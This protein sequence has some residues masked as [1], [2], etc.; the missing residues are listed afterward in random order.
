MTSSKFLSDQELLNQFQPFVDWDLK[1]QDVN[2]IS[3][4]EFIPMLEVPQV[5]RSMGIPADGFTFVLKEKTYEPNSDKIIWPQDG[6]IAFVEEEGKNMK[7]VLLYISETFEGEK[8]RDGPMKI[9]LDYTMPLSEFLDMIKD[10]FEIPREN[11]RRLRNL[12]DHKLFSRDDLDKSLID[13]G[14]IEGGQRI[15]FERGRTPLKG[16]FDINVKYTI[17]EEGKKHTLCENFIVE[18]HKQVKDYW[19]NICSTFNLDPSEHH[20]YEA[21]WHG[22][23]GNRIRHLDQTIEVVGAKP[24]D[25]WVIMHDS[26]GVSQEMLD[27]EVH[28][29]KSGLPGDQKKIGSVRIHQG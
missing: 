23:P 25:N 4:Q 17:F 19:P 27:F 21:N 8:P 12:L 28:F 13:L 16:G 24:G 18:L 20:L 9:A 6:S 29:S 14:Y 5:E 1:I 26:M 3:H 10:K 7:T 15:R 11:A 2:V 22:D